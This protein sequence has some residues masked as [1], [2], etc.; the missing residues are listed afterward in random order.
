MSPELIDLDAPARCRGRASRPAS[1]P[2][3]PVGPPAP[4]DPGPPLVAALPAILKPCIEQSPA[5]VMT[6]IALDRVIRGTPFDRLFE[7]SAQGE[8]TREFTRE[9]LVLVMLDVV[10]GFNPSTRSAFLERGLQLI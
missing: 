7:L 9:H 3:R 1:P 4:L 10:C 6:R 2:P 5:T 8:Y